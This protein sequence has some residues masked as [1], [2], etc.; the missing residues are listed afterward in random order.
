MFSTV[1]APGS[2]VYHYDHM[3]VDLM[4]RAG[5]RR[6]CQPAA[7]PGEAAAARAGTRYGRT[8]PWEPPYTGSLGPGRYPRPA[9]RLVP[10]RPLSYEEGDRSLIRAV[11]GED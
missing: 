8:R 7:I 2:N 9:S 1:L 11:P 5:G 10:D 4:R 6:I 3:H